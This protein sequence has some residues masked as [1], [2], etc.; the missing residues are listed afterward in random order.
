MGISTNVLILGLIALSTGQLTSLLPNLAPIVPNLT[1]IV[2][3]AIPVAGVPGYYLTNALY[4]LQSW[5]A[6]SPSCTLLDSQEYGALCRVSDT[7]ANIFTNSTDSLVRPTAM[8]SAEAICDADCRCIH[9]AYSGSCGTS[10][11]DGLGYCLCNMDTPGTPSVNVI[12]CALEDTRAA[13]NQEQV[14]CSFDA[15]GS[16]FNNYA[17]NLD[18]VCS[19]GYPA[20]YNATTFNQN[21]CTYYSNVPTGPNYPGPAVYCV[22][23]NGKQ[24][25]NPSI[26]S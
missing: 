12:P 9:G 6:T 4:A 15:L 20:N 5:N 1:P 24:Y 17:C 10:T 26:W 25:S 13:L 21:N 11:V 8:F 2:N 14:L 18:C 23:G 3:S 7:L 19:H 22:C 16:F